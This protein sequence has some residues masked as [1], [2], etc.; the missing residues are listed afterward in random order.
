MVTVSFCLLPVIA[1]GHRFKTQERAVSTGVLRLTRVMT[2]SLATCT[3]IV[4]TAMSLGTTATTGKVCGLSQNSK[5]L[6]L[7]YVFASAWLDRASG[8]PIVVGD[9]NRVRVWIPDRS[10]E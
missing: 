4:L 1:T 9:D 7:A 3:S 5:W 6:C 8:S 10:R 2:T